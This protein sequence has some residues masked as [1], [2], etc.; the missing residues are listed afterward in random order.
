MSWENTIK[1]WQPKP[2]PSIEEG[3]TAPNAPTWDEIMETTQNEKH[4]RFLEEVRR[5][6]EKR[7]Q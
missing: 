2:P 3:G 6:M 4:Y 7:L 1:R 5:L